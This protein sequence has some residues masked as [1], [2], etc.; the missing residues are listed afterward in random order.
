MYIG[1]H[2]SKA[3]VKKSGA[4]AAKR[5]ADESLIAS[6]D[7]L[8]GINSRKVCHQ[9]SGTTSG[10]FN[11]ILNNGLCSGV[12]LDLERKTDKIPRMFTLVWDDEKYNNF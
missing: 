3:A 5:K 2:S 10:C 7:E 12:C 8:F 11:I 4:Q 9:L 1:I 6:V